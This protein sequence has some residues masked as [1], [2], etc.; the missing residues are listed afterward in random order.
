MDIKKTVSSCL[1]LMVGWLGSSSLAA[2]QQ[3]AGKFVAGINYPAGLPNS[4]TNTGLL[5][6]GLTPEQTLTG[7]FNGD[8]IPD[9]VMTAGC[10]LGYS[11]NCVNGSAVA[12]FLGNGDGTFQ[13][14]KVSYGTQSPNASF[15]IGDFN[16][17]GN[18]DVIALSGPNGK[19]SCTTCGFANVFLGDGK[20]GLVLSQ[21]YVVAGVLTTNNP[22]VV[23][24]YFNNGNR[25]LDF[26]VVGTCETRSLCNQTGDTVV[27][28]FLGN[29]DGT[30]GTPATSEI[31][32]LSGT[33]AGADFN[34]DGNFDLL[35]ASTNPFNPGYTI[36]Y[37][38][39]DGTF[40]TCLAAPCSPFPVL[41]QLAFSPSA[42]ATGDFNSDGNQDLAIAVP[43]SGTSPG[44][45]YI[46]LGNGDGTFQT[47]VQ[48]GAGGNAVTVGDFNGD[49]NPDL[50]VATET[51]STSTATLLIN[52]G[53]GLFNSGP[54]I[55]LGGWNTVSIAAADFNG[56]GHLDIAL[57]ST[58]S[59]TALIADHCPDGTI[60]VLLGNGDGTMQAAFL[61]ASGQS[62]SGFG[63]LL[64]DVNG[65]GI[66]D[67]ITG[68]IASSQGGV[69]VQLGLGSGNYGPGTFYPAGISPPL[70]IMAGNLRNIP[71]KID[72]VVAGGG[73][74][75]LLGNGDGT[76]Q[77]P[78]VY[79]TLTSVSD[80]QLGD[81]A[82]KGNLGVAVLHKVGPSG[83]GNGIVG[84][85]L[86]NG[87]GT[88][89]PEITTNTTE[90]IGYGLTVGDFNHDGKADVAVVG[91]TLPEPSLGGVNAVTVLL[92]N[93]D[94]TLAVKP[95]PVNAVGFNLCVQ[96]SGNICA[97]LASYP[98]AGVAAG[99]NVGASIATNDLNGDGNLDLVIA[100][101]CALNTS[102]STG[103]ITF[104]LGNGDG[105]FG[106]GDS[107]QGPPAMADA[108]YSGLT[109]AD[110]NGDGKPDIV[111]TTG[112]GVA[113]FL[114]TTSNPQIVNFSS[115]IVYAAEYI[116]QLA[117]PIVVDLNGDGAPD[118][119]VDNGSSLAILF[120]RGLLSATTTTTLASSLNP[121]VL[122]QSLVLTASVTSTFGTPTGTVTFYDGGISIGTSILN[123]S[124]EAALTTN[125]LSSGTH[126]ITASYSGDSSHIASNSPVLSL[127]VNQAP[128]ITSGSSAMFIATTASSFTVTATGFPTPALTETG[129]LPS[130]V[131]FNAS[132]GLLSGA[133]VS[134]SVGTYNIIFSASNGVGAAATQS[135]T[136]T[137]NNTP[138]GTNVSVQPADTTTGTSPV[139][140]TFST[141]AQG[142]ITSLTTSSTGPAP[143]GGFALGT[144]ANY[145]NL[146]TTAVYSGSISLCINYTGIS[147]TASPQLFHYNGTAWVN[148]TTSVDAVN[149]IVCGSV[150]SLSPFA[151]FQPTTQP[152]A[153]TSGNST[154]FTTSI[155]GS[156]TLTA[157][158]LPTPT[159]TETGALPT[160]VSFNASTGVLGG[161][162]AAGTG[163]AYN[164]IFTASNG[165]GTAATQSF[166]L[167]VNQAPAVTSANTALFSFG[168]AGT[169]AVTATGFPTPTLSET[170]TLPS[171]VTFNAST[172]A[173]SGTPTSGT[174]GT[175]NIA[176]TASNGV[177][178]PATQSFTLTVNPA[179][180]TIALTGVPSSATFGQ[181]PFTISTSATSGLPVSLAATGNCSL[182]AS[183]LSLTAAGSCTVTA[184]Q[185]GNSNYSAAQN[186]SSSFTI[187]QDPTTTVVS[188]SPGTAQYSDYGSF[189]A[190]VTPIS[191]GGQTLSGN[192]QFYLNGSALG[193]AVTINSSGV[194]RLAQVQVNLSAASYSVKAVFSS[195]NPNFTGGTGTTTQNVTQE[196][197]FILYSGDSIA[198][199]GTSLNL[200]ATVWDSAAAGYPGVN[201]ETG[202]NATI[203][204]I[205]KMRIAF[206]IYPAGSCAS[207]TP[208]T[209]YAQVVL[210]S[211]PGVGTA[212]STLSSNSEVSYCVV[213]RLVAGGAGGTNLFYVAPNAQAVGV[214]FY[215]NSGQ[216][217]TG[218]GWVIDPT[219]SHG[220]FGF[221]ARYNS[222]GSPKG[223]MV[224]VYRSTY[225]GVLADFIIKSNALTALQ[226][227]GTTFPISSTL[228]GKANVQV[229][230]ASDGYSL[231][232]AG[233]SMFSAT[234]TDSSQNGTSGKQFSLIVYDSSGVPYH[235][236][237]AGTPLQGGNVV[238]HSH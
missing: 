79:Q 132:T 208:S 60:S 217:A 102:C 89:Q 174:V 7:D 88:L 156:F 202:A 44:S 125:G 14:P 17:D 238:V 94:G 185:S 129:A 57:S 2:G 198:Q 140:L 180:Q 118:I 51:P 192:V 87:D 111:A 107:L 59:E 110:L 80:A 119:A 223:Q 183:V 155:S 34:N 146:A 166:T 99:G 78:T 235:S 41:T 5:I 38:N 31:G 150:T 98:A 232:S 203:G 179:T 236:V 196:N 197:A 30:F 187:G 147:F 182:S 83:S 103:S 184:T 43:P 4:P 206:D 86:G 53:T 175:Y 134:N 25:I 62:G 173:L 153:I 161:T 26:A 237:P 54:T 46:L 181:G 234:V 228:Q 12:V 18:L 16:G 77:S 100:N 112:S 22:S 42:V 92:G 71:G 213:S 214:D 200:R 97:N 65:D 11:V 139:T 3:A 190:T 116:S 70:A 58:C 27:S 138:T 20:G 10:S 195:T 50:A 45:T 61:P 220:N 90:I 144:P 230:R 188:V 189:A 115:G 108:N 159:L 143:A 52:D 207:G 131:S 149:H 109:L 23:T 21:T 209:S 124:S 145:Y 15:A 167:T 76:F 117:R 68:Q 39:G 13:A 162:P 113:V 35:I 212:T 171:G 36:L 1:V 148:V 28:I 157:T 130:G 201:P 8:G 177:G 141:V 106:Y 219:G 72:I 121:S 6:G 226:F 221:N 37:G 33:I 193:S 136:L 19:N 191:A 204:D 95:N 169:F 224:Y 205:T 66:P 233:N 164:I 231:F 101:Q 123:G 142:G 178:A 81:F 49:G 29:G 82:A 104:W 229:N 165:V 163:G 186:I 210:T 91:T 222:A 9:I 137:V 218:G 55:P 194:A 47:P 126:S 199:V 69:T 151:I 135:F 154:T 170:G 40:R 172:G 227:S 127:I 74:G 120:N 105:T 64:A 133:P 96:E 48:Y 216:F 160:G 75:V 56:D 93:G 225:N 84:I 32:N 168:G 85:F 114:N 215:L 73:V 67:L 176:F 128:A 122:G 158:G 152:P 24:G 211:T 63:A